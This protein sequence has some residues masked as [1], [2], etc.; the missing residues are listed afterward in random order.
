[1][2]RKGIVFQYGWP[3]FDFGHICYAWPNNPEEMDKMALGRLEEIGNIIGEN[4]GE[5]SLEFGCGKVPTNA[6]RVDAKGIVAGWYDNGRWMEFFDMSGA[7]FINGHNL[8]SWLDNVVAFNLG[9]D[10]LEFLS[11]EI[12]A[13]RVGYDSGSWEIKYALPEKSAFMDNVESSKKRIDKLYSVGKIGE[14]PEVKVEGFS[15]VLENS[16]GRIVV[17]DK[18]LRTEG[19]SSEYVPGSSFVAAKLMNLTRS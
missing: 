15:L 17:D 10:V 4:F 16:N 11:P 9:S 13:P 2:D 5:Y 8:D 18:Y 12:L 7:N 19:F 3:N 14:S 1:M 6:V